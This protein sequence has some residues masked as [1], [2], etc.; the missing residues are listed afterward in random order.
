MRDRSDHDALHI[1]HHLLAEMLGLHR[2]AITTQSGNWKM[3]V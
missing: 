3:P 1:T 2:P